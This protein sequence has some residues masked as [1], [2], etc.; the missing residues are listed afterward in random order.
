MMNS[1][2]RLLSPFV[3]APGAPA[4]PFR[5]FQTFNASKK[6]LRIPWSY[7]GRVGL[8]GDHDAPAVVG[9][10]EDTPGAHR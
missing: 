1:I 9:L 8:F 5:R 4:A 6:I 7:A 2:V 10:G 3:V